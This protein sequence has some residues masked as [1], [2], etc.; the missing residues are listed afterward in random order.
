MAKQSALNT[1]IFLNQYEVSGELV[2]AVMGFNRETPKTN[3][4]GQA[5][6]RRVVANIDT[7]SEM[8]GFFDGD[9]DKIDE[10]LEALK[11]GSADAKLCKSIGAS[12][13]DVCYEQLVI[14][15]SQPRSAR[16]GE[17][18]LINF[19][20]VGSNGPTRSQQLTTQKQTVTGNLSGTG[21]NMG[22]TTV[23][24]DEF[25]VVYRILSGTF[26]SFDLDVQ[27]SSDD[28]GG[29]AYADIADLAQASVT[30]VGVHRKS[31]TAATEAYKRL[32]VTNWSGTSVVLLVTAGIMAK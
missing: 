3:G 17:A 23:T 18:A 22:V 27:E 16:N 29:D 30:A 25:Q 12:L 4:F 21:V 31:T 32:S 10:I 5:G 19:S 14:V 15:S 7:T 6:P 1:K 24:T 9:D 26:T 28:G 2:A 20:S 13:G 11:A 8:N